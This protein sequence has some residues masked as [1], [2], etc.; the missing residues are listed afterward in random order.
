MKVVGS[1]LYLRYLG[2]SSKN[3]ATHLQDQLADVV[4]LL[5]VPAIATSQPG[6]G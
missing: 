3:L 2:W 5:V 1:H 6:E 4:S